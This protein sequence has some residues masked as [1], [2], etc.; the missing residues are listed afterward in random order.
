MSN[1][2]LINIYFF[3][4]FIKFLLFNEQKQCIYLQFSNIS[5]RSFTISIFR[6]TERS[7]GISFNKYEI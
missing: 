4:C 5:E 7:F 1:I 6:P 3:Y 2:F